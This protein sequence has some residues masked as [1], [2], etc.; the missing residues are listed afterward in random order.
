M[1]RAEEV[2][3]QRL[4]RRTALVLAFCCVAAL[5]AAQGGAKATHKAAQT[6]PSPAAPDRAYLQKIWD[7]W[8]TLDPANAAPYYSKDPQN[9]YYDLTPL[10][11]NGWAEYEKGV[12]NVLGGFASLKCRLNDD[13]RVQSQGD[14]ALATATVHADIVNKD[15]TTGTLDMRWTGILHREGGKWLIVH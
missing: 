13:A 15:G 9:V 5:A 3:V 14:G 11:Y 8:S 6:A 1:R 10:K 4:K 2:L 12:K 7:A